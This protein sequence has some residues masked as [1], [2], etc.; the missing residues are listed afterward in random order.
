MVMQSTLARPFV[1]QE[2][3]IS[4]GE[5]LTEPGDKSVRH[6]MAQAHCLLK[7]C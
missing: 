6:K 2:V 3:S 7:V 1:L 5:N 4:V